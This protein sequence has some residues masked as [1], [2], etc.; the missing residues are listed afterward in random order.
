MV[1]GERRDSLVILNC[2]AVGCDDRHHYFTHPGIETAGRLGLLV[3]LP[4]T[5][6]AAGSSPVAPANS[7][8]R[9]FSS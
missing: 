6:E 3:R 9:A 7:S 2:Q 8:L 5:Q 4:V 1:V